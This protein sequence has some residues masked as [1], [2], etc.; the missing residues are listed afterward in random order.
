MS[1][2]PQQFRKP[3]LAWL[4]WLLVV[5][6]GLSG[7]ALVTRAAVGP[8]H[9]VLFINRPLVAEGILALSATI[10]FL[11]HTSPA[12]KQT[13]IPRL[14]FV[15]FAACLVL[16]AVYL[17]NSLSFPLVCD[18]YVLAADG[19]GMDWATAISR[20]THTGIDRF[21]RPLADASLRL[22]VLWAGTNPVGWHILGC[23]LHVVNTLLVG[24]LAWRL[25]TRPWLAI[26]AAAL[27]G[28]HGSR[29]EAIALLARFDQLATLFVLAGLLLFVGYLE[30]G[31]L[32]VLAGSCVAMLA[33]L[34][35]KESAYIFPLLAVLLLWWR[36]QLNRLK[37]RAT[38]P[39]FAITAAVFAWRW[40]VLGGIGG[41]PDLVSGRP[42]ILNIRVLALLNGLTMRLWGLLYFP[43]NWSYPPEWWLVAAMAAGF[44]AVICLVFFSR[45][46]RRTLWFATA[47]TIIASLPVAHMLLI[48]SDLRGAVHT[49]LTSIGFCLFLAAVIDGMPARFLSRVAGTAILLFQ[50]AMLSHNLTIWDRTAQL[51]DRACQMLAREAAQSNRPIIVENPPLILD[52]VPFFTNGL[53]ECIGMKTPARDVSVEY[54]PSIATRQAG[55]P[56]FVWDSETRR[57][58]RKLAPH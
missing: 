50:F 58:V 46:D 21:F 57:F 49:Y 10:L 24:V 7:A 55:I 48:G 35:S 8:F 12:T 30:F 45:A 28:I 15:G 39:F 18:D 32:P 40:N 20:F 51:A 27:F 2:P 1:L 9:F 33:G 54:G 6:L 42:Q 22:D 41:Y 34:L 38:I 19:R 4:R 13:H 56:V 43:I 36:G 47:F 25:F 11:T 3:A 52:G 29:P 31:H 5:A 37:L 53:T 26:W 16:T 17:Y 14:P 44:A 23:A